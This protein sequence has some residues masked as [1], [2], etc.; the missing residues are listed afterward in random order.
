[1]ICSEVQRTLV[2]SPPELWSEL[3]DPAA[4]GRLLGD[5]GDVRTTRVEPEKAVEWEAENAS[6]TVLIKPSGW[7]TTVTLKV[8]RELAGAQT[9]GGSA[10]EADAESAAAD[11]PSAATAQPYAALAEPYATTDDQRAGAEDWQLR[12]AVEPPGGAE[13]QPEPAA[14]RAESEC[15]PEPAAGRAESEWEERELEEPEWEERELRDPEWEESES[16]DPESWQRDWESEPEPIPRRSFFARLF[17][18]RRRE[19]RLHPAATVAATKTPLEWTPGDAG[20]D[21]DGEWPQTTDAT[22]PAGEPPPA[23]PAAAEPDATIAGDEQVADARQA[24][25]PQA[26][27]P[28]AEQRGQAADLAAELMAAEEVAAQEVTA[29]LTAV[30]DRLGAAH[31]RPF[32]RA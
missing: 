25:A 16:E 29:V 24:D 1:M 5:F 27:A 26:D 17:T 23:I 15:Q 9:P 12:A 6:G 18:R 2:K 10:P 14:G 7:G 22:G 28:V 30:L 20:F 13:P 31:H 19:E 3:S 8:K 21:A 4:L 32:S 11:E